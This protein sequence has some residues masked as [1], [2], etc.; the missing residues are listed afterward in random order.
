MNVYA[1]TWLDVWFPYWTPRRV[2]YSLGV[3]VVCWHLARL[4]TLTNMVFFLLNI[5]IYTSCLTLLFYFITSVRLLTHW[6]FSLSKWTR[7]EIFCTSV[8]LKFVFYPS[9][10]FFKVYS[11]FTITAA[12]KFRLNFD[13]SFL[14]FDNHFHSRFENK[15]GQ[16]VFNLTR[17]L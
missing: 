15:G 11:D 9:W 4:V 2:P 13:E 16:R 8:P 14:L 6:P 10:P 12:S 3:Q 17:E 5:Y 7:K 1:Y